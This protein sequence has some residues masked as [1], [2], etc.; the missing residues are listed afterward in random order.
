MRQGRSG[1]RPE[2]VASVSIADRCH[3]FL[4]SDREQFCLQKVI[5]GFVFFS[6]T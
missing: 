6:G 4:G 3:A 5:D 2:A 1:E